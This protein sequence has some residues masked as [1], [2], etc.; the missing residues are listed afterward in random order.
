MVSWL[1]MCLNGADVDQVDLGG[2]AFGI[3]YLHMHKIL[4]SINIPIARSW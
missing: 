2:T 1:L 4:H 3:A